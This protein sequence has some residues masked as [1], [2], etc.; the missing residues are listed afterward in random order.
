MKYTTATEALMGGI[1]KILIFK[2]LI[3]SEILP[4]YLV[5]R[6][7]VSCSYQQKY[8]LLW[9]GSRG[10]RKLIGICEQLAAVSHRIW[11]TGSRNLEKSATE[12]C[13]P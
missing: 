11:Q 9:L 4:V 2:I 5:D 8:W 13:G 6:L 3:L 10:C 1:L 12:N 7:S